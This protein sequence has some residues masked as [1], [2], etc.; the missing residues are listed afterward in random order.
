MSNPE[1]ERVPE[2]PP[3][4]VIVADA[5]GMVW[6][7]TEHDA[8]LIPGRR[9]DHCLVFSCSLAVRRVWDYPAGWRDLPAAQLMEVS[10]RL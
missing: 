2:E 7:V 5:D 3:P 4:T 10:W 6:R 9:G 1:L 8:R